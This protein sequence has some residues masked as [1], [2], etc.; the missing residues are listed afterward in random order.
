MNR[1]HWVF[2]FIFLSSCCFGFWQAF[3][4][5][6]EHS[7][8][9]RQMWV[10]L[11]NKKAWLLSEKKRILSQKGCQKKSLL[12]VAQKQHVVILKSSPQSIQITADYSDLL[13]F[14]AQLDSPRCL[15]GRLKLS[16][17]LG[18]KQKK[19]LLDYKEWL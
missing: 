8:K 7:Q 10:G 17:S 6:K 11:E 18:K 9:Q 15:P 12:S 16:F 4:E 19:I 5:R 14:I 1:Y 13:G 3:S 2:V